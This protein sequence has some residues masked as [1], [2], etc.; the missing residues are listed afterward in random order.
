MR[1]KRA[2]GKDRRRAVAQLVV[3]FAA[4]DDDQIRLLHRPAAHGAHHRGVV[5]RD[6]AAAFLRVEI[7]GAG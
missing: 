7:D 2:C 6:Q 1:M 5:G 3:E 4:N